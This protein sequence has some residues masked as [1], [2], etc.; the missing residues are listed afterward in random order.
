[1]GSRV[2]CLSGECKLEV[3]RGDPTY[4]SEWQYALYFSV[5]AHSSPITIYKGRYAFFVNCD[6][7]T[8]NVHNEDATFQIES[9][10]SYF[11]NL[12]NVSS[13]KTK[14]TFSST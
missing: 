2:N 1:M 13:T 6:S 10:S 14:F 11:I 9:Y 7:H 8:V 5:H 4:V 3:K 12:T